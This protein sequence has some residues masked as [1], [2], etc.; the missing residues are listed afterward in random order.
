MT[1]PEVT[2]ILAVRSHSPL[3]CSSP[4]GWAGSAHFACKVVI[5]FATACRGPLDLGEGTGSHGARPYLGGVQGGTPP[6][7]YWDGEPE[8][9]P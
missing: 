4:G 5:S 9:G 2:L 6:G 7:L 1:T 8:E 3:R